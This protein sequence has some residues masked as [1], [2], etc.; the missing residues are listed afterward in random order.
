MGRKKPFIDKKKSSTFHLLHRSQRDVSEHV[1]YGGDEDGQ[2]EG[3]ANSNTNI[4]SSGMVLWPSPHNSAETN[5]AVL[6]SDYHHRGNNN[7]N[8]INQAQDDDDD[9]ATAAN[10]NNKSSNTSSNRMTEWRLKL[11]QAGLLENEQEGAEKYVKEITGQGVFLHANGRVG[12]SSSA[13]AATNATQRVGG[14]VVNMEDTD[15]LELNKTLLDNIPLT[16]AIDEDIQELLFSDTV[17]FD[18]YE[19]L[20]DEFILDAAQEPPPPTSSTTDDN[21]STTTTTA[22]FDYDA[23]I[24]KLLEKA[25]RER[26]FGGATGVD[27]AAAHAAGASDHAFFSKLQPLH[28]RHDNDNDDDDHD[29]FANIP[30]DQDNDDDDMDMDMDDDGYS[31]TQLMMENMT[32][33]M[34]VIPALSPDEERALCEKFAETLAEYDTDSDVEEEEEEEDDDDEYM[35]S[36]GRNAGNEFIGLPLE[37]NA[38]VEAALDEFLIQHQNLDQDDNLMVPKTAT[39][40]DSSALQAARKIGGSGFCV[41]LGKQM[42]RDCPWSSSTENPAMDN[43]NEPT[44]SVQQVLALATSRLAEPIVKP[45]TEEILIDGKS[46]FSERHRNPWDCESILSTYSNLD[47]NPVTID[48]TSGS[49]RRA[50]QRQQNKKGTLGS[51]PLEQEAEAQIRLSSKTGLPLGVFPTRNHHDDSNSDDDSDGNGCD[52]TMV[53]VNKGQAR[54]KLESAEEKKARKAAI[55]RERHAARLQKKVTRQVF[56]TEL[57]RRTADVTANDTTGKSVFRYS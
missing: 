45:P 7:N 2:E 16:E 38:L 10:N 13:A 28:E 51:N 1:F 42:V 49:T 31:R 29:S 35:A 34:G 21:N 43:N 56:Q 41:L 5:R 20:N 14:G 33:A 39:E 54:S 57:A 25:R 17:D 36:G 3:D 47:N 44:E 55:K 18:D 37:G 46:Y 12:S 50:R 30:D 15:V 40:H 32:T 4:S 9:T 24:Q 48:A 27:A 19:D 6:L 23:H 53:S 52:D 11:Q 26:S 8:N 22:A